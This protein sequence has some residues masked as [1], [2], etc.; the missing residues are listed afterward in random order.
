MFATR[1]AT[2]CGRQDSRSSR[3]LTLA[4]GIGANTAIFSVVNAVI[5]RPLGYPRARAAGL[6]LEPVPA[7]GIRPVLD[8]AAGVPRVPGADEVV[9]V[10]R[11]VHD[12]SG[13]PDRARSSA[14]RQLR[15]WR[16]R[17]SSRSLGVNALY[18]RTFDDAE[19]RPNGPPVAMLSLRGV[20][21]GVRRPRGR[22]GLA[23]RGQRPPPHRRRHHAAA[24]STSPTSTSKSGLPLV[25]NPANRQ[26]RGSH[27]L[28]LI[29]RLADGAT[30]AEREGGARHAARRLADVDRA[31]G[32]RHQRSAHAGHAEPSPASRSAAGCKSSAARGRPSSCCRAR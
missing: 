10:G 22:P 18:G 28:Y 17:T 23:G 27:F 25:I 21:V 16:R 1:C 6:H 15:A 5:L 30:L 13:E 32:R 7:D 31:R 14:P 19:T 12:G 26:N 11:R 24:I 29:G 20:A 2:C 4:L 9:F 3:C 8:L